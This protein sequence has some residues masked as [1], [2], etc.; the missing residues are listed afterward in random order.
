MDVALLNQKTLS[1]QITLGQK[2]GTINDQLTTQCSIN[3]P[4]QISA[5]LYAKIF[6][7]LPVLD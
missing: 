4:V 2:I 6:N 3:R 1:W 7:K 5:P